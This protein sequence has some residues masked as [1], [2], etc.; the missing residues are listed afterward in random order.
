MPDE[1]VIRLGRLSVFRLAPFDTHNNKAMERKATVATGIFMSKLFTPLLVLAALGAANVVLAQEEP[2]SPVVVREQ[3]ADHDVYVGIGLFE[4][5]L[6]L[7]TEVVTDWGN[8][9]LRAG[10]FKNVDEGIAF[11]M[12]WRRPIATDAD[13]ELIGDGRAS[14]YYMG[15]FAGELSSEMLAGKHVQRIGAGAEMG[16]HWVT[17]YTRSEF[18]VGLGA[19]KGEENGGFKLPSEPTIFFSINVALGY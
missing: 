3:S 8:F 6:N 10:R 13:G 1:R 4:D 14:G 12:S 5:M 18:T 17:D 19:M 16:Y 9:M 7:N 2:A 11:N 15:L